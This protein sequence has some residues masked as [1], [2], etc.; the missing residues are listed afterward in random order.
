MESVTVGTR[1]SAFFIASARSSKD[2][3]LS[4]PFRWTSNNSIIRVS[5]ASGS[6][7]VTTTSGFFLGI[8]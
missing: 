5:V 7:W 4:S 8:L 6:L 3:G 2:M 1:T